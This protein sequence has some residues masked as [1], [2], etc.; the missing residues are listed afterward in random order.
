MGAEEKQISFM[1]RYFIFKKMRN[2]DAKKMEKIIQKDI[3]I[4]NVPDF[5]EQLDSETQKGPIFI[6]S[7]K[8][9]KIRK[10]TNMQ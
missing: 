10:P 2:V 9:I 5:T 4:E 3:Q 1:N 6:K 8:T 7:N